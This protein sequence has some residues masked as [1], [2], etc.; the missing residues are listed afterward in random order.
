[1]FKCKY[2]QEV[3]DFIQDNINMV[4]LRKAIQDKFGIVFNKSTI[5]YYRR[6]H[7]GIK[8]K[9]VKTTPT[10][11][12]KPVGTERV[13]KDG[14]IRIIVDGGIERLKHHVVWET[15]NPPIKDGECLLFLDGNKLNCS[16]ENLY[17]IKRKY[18]S[19][20]NCMIKKM[21]II[22]PEQRKSLIL[23]AGLKIEAD[24]RELKLKAK[25]PRRRPKGNNYIIVKELYEQGLL[26]SQIAN[27]LNKSVSVIHWTLR[28]LKLGCYDD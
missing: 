17:L 26:P 24:E 28:R 16:I 9:H 13:D 27:K 8:I 7:R 19:T 11:L 25:S 12:T 15:K 10:F 2:P 21:G 22:T 4:G 18:I 6:K 20:L 23:C 3:Y 1:M 14:Y 5:D